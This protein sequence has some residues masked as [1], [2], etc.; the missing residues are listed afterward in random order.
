[1]EF[2]RKPTVLITASS[3]GEKGHASLLEILK[4]IEADINEETQLVISYVK[5]KVKSTTIT[6][7]TTLL[8]VNKVMEAF[9]KKIRPN[10]QP[11]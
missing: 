6:D 9:V 2:S 4:I 3:L 5:T 11:E 7:V 10:S 1:M 8:E